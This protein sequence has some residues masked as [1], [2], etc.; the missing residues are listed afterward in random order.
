M[1]LGI[2]MSP[3]VVRNPRH[4]SLPQDDSAGKKGKKAAKGGSAKKGK[5]GKKEEAAPAKDYFLTAQSQ[6]MDLT[7]PA[8]ERVWGTSVK[9]CG[10]QV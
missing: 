1:P 5:K 8:G 10:E 2:M 9:G 7:Q 4:S 3:V 6:S